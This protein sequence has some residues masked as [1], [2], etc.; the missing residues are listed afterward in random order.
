VEKNKRYQYSYE[1]IFLII[2]IFIALIILFAFVRVPH[3]QIYELQNYNNG[4]FNISGFVSD[5]KVQD[6]YTKFKLN[7]STN[8]IQ[9]IAFYKITDLNNGSQAN[10]IC[11]LQT[12]N[13]GKECIINN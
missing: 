1:I 10:I 9:I 12:N 13:Y 3:K 11:N 4:K 8:S 7:D 2:I 6:N 5:L